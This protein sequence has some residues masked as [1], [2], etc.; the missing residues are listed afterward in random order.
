M[1]LIKQLPSEPLRRFVE[2]FWLYQAAETAC[3]QQVLLPT[4]NVALVINLTRNGMA[5]FSRHDIVRRESLSG[6]AVF[7][8]L[9]EYCHIL[10]QGSAALLGV[11]FKPGGAFPF[12][13]FPLGDL[14][15][16]RVPLEVVW[17]DQATELRD[18]IL[19]ASSVAAKF[20]VVE[21]FLQDRCD[22]A[23]LNHPGVRFA[24]AHL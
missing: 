17:G 13:G 23:A 9:S 18:R 5:V 15:N 7:G 21:R 6:C 16:Q 2:H 1:T 19:A 4:V 22:P 12:F 14:E 8:P 20:A 24:L 10:P 3:L 11:Q